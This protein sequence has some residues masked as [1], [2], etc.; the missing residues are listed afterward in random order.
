MKDVKKME[1]PISMKI[2]ALKNKLISEINN[3]KLP[4]Y[5]ILPIIKELYEQINQLDIENTRK[6][7]AEYENSLKG[8]K[9]GI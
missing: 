5:I 2:I 8:E 1:M 4:T 3:A 9:D 7:K 6:E